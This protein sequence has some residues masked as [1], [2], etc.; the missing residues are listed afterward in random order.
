[1]DEALC[2]AVERVY[3]EFA[4]VPPPQRLDTSPEHDGDATF[5]ALTSAPLR[6]LAAE[7]IGPYAGS[8]MTTMGG[9]QD[10]QYFLPRILEL[11]LTDTDWLG[12]DPE[13]IAK[14]LNYAPWTDWP[15][16]RRVA[17]LALFDAAF[18]WSISTHPKI[19]RRAEDWLCALAILNAPIELR[20]A[21]WRQLDSCEAALQLAWFVMSG[22]TKAG[23]PAQIEGAYWADVTVPDRE[24]VARWLSSDDTM[25]QLYNWLERAPEDDRWMI[26]HALLVLI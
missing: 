12:T 8:A 13:N 21:Q 9:P 18:T 2:D 10:Y 23:E 3:R 24:K 5:R 22:L 25:A 20:L 1:M 4:G 26:E 14:T 19:V 15:A 11:S 17:V 7:A 16:R 6:E